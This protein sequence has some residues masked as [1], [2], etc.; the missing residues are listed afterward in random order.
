MMPN[1]HDLIFEYM[2]SITAI[3]TSKTDSK[4]VFLT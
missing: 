3:M 1:S 4:T 2:D